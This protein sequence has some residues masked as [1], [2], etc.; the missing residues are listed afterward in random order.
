[1]WMQY[2]WND[3]N[4]TCC[5]TLAYKV[6]SVWSSVLAWSSAAASR[7]FATQKCACSWKEAQ[8]LKP[9][10]LLGNLVAWTSRHE[11]DLPTALL[12]GEES[13][14]YTPLSAQHKVTWIQRSVK[15]KPS[16]FTK[17]VSCSVMIPALECFAKSAFTSC[18]IWTTSK[19]QLNTCLLLLLRHNSWYYIWHAIQLLLSGGARRA[20]TDLSAPCSV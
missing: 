7:P 4:V 19:P 3:L 8:H 5:C 9:Y 1:M 17:K 16:S 12:N 6:R 10:F 2:W 11:T 15:R 20:G 14:R 13:G 18:W